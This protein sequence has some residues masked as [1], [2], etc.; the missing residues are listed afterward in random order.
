MQ[1]SAGQNENV[2]VTGIGKDTTLSGAWQVNFPQNMGAPA[3]IT[4]PELISLHKHENEGVKYFSGTATYRKAFTLP[5]NTRTANKRLFLDLGRVEVMAEV[6]LNGKNLGIIWQR[7]YKVDITE[8]VKG[9]T[10]HLE[11][12]V[13]NLWPNRLIGDEQVPEMYKFPAPSAAAASGP[14]AVLSSG[15]IEALPDWYKKGEPKPADGRVTFTTW[16]HYRKDSPLLES[17]LIGP[18]V[19]RTAVFKPL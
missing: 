9:G 10:N 5:T 8:A 7:P 12:K 16:K 1:D 19:I 11:V 6:M 14:F 18:V 15:G 3:Q 13:T 17:G 2:Q 4:L